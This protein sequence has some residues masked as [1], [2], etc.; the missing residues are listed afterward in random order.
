MDAPEKKTLQHPVAIRPMAEADLPTAD[1]IMRVAFGTFLGVPEPATFMGDASYVANRYKASPGCAFTAVHEGEVVG[2]TF[3]A[4][5]GSVGSFGPLT[6]KA[7]LW[8][9]GIGRRLMAPVMALFE[10]WGV[11]HV[12]LFTF[13]HSP[14]H[15]GFYQTLGFW[16]GHVTAVMARPV[17]VAA[18]VPWSALA[19][20]PGDRAAGIAGCRRVAAAQV[21]GLDL[22]SE[23]DAAAALG[24]GDTVVLQDSGEVVGFAVCHVGANTEAGS[25]ACYVKFAAVLP[26][27]GAPRRF[28]NLLDACMAFAASRGAKVLL[29]GVSTARHEAYRRLLARGFRSVMQGVTMHRANAPAYDRPDRF[30]IDDLR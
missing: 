24:L 11:A 25:G 18:E 20:H 29:A 3:A 1:R 13:A 5:W 27:E 23:I 16:P 4:R 14:K 2:S 15:V 8:D 10:S 19:A 9:M 30:V 6:V 21:P 7:E 26:G 22:T 28:E 17:E 12:G